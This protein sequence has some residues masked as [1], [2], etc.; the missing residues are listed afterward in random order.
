MEVMGRGKWEFKVIE[1][2][3]LTMDMQKRASHW[4]SRGE[5]R[6]CG[7]HYRSGYHFR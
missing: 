5:R 6:H 1:D 7:L 3:L 4:T 2:M